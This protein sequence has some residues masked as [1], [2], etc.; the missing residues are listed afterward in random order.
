M[1][2]KDSRKEQEY[3]GLVKKLYWGILKLDIQ[4]NT[5]ISGILQRL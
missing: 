1:N 2:S 3:Q 5:G 4:I